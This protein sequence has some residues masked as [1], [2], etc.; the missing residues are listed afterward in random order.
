MKIK[1]KEAT[2]TIKKKGMRKKNWIQN[3]IRDF[4]TY[5]AGRYM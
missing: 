3:E 5:I 2:T 1:F 4:K